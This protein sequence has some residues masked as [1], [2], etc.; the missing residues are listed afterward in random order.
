MRLRNS[1]DRRTLLWVFVLTP[2]FVLAQY[3]RPELVPFLAPVSCYFALAC[4]VIAHNHNHTPTFVS[5]R[6]N[7]VFGNWLSIFYGYPTFAWIPTHNMNHHKH[8]NKAGDATITWRLTNEHKLWVAATYFFVSAYHQATPTK[9]FLDKAREKNPSLYR[10]CMT[11]WF[12]FVGVHVTAI[13]A[14]VLAHG[15]KV[16]LLTWVGASFVPGFFALWTI[17]LF[18]YEQHVH[19]DPWSEH[20][21]SRNF[22]GW[23]LN[24]L[25][26]NNG[27]HTAHHEHPGAHWT[28]LPEL[29]ARV[30]DQIHPD[31]NE[32]NMWW[33]WIKQYAL[34]PFS[35]RFGTQQV[36]RA[37]FEPPGG[38]A[39]DLAC[40]EVE[41]GD[42]G[43]N[44]ARA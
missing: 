35:S 41:I 40:D 9:Q 3:L 15:W 33:Y 44:A 12:W 23:W 21:H 14:L 34:R 36:G 10:Q 8:V 43:T 20:S 22:V 11:Q 32:R 6:A 1:G 17:H 13:T 37:P 18:N 30:A 4:G 26:F 5:K 27:Y 16:G 38:D 39:V 19:T 2:G 31:L 28:Q 29:H 25:L 7:R 42:A 24:F